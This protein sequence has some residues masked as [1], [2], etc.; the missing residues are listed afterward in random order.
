MPHKRRCLYEQIITNDIHASYLVHVISS[1]VLCVRKFGI[2][3]FS[4]T[5]S[6]NSASSIFFVMLF[7]CSIILFQFLFEHFDGVIA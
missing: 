4:Y 7:S 6:H 3:G 5:L 1:A 2:N